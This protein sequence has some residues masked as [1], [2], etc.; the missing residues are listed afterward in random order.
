[1]REKAEFAAH[2]DYFHDFCQPDQLFSTLGSALLPSPTAYC[3]S[4]QSPHFA[5]IT[6]TDSTAADSIAICLLHTHTHVH[7]HLTKP[8]SLHHTLFLV[9]RSESGGFG[10]TWP[11][12]C[13]HCIFWLQGGRE[14]EGEYCRSLSLHVVGAA[15]RGRGMRARW[16]RGESNGSGSPSRHRHP[17][18]NKLAS[19][20]EIWHARNAATTAFAVAASADL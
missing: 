8:P 13:Y 20:N 10:S 12:V 14:R 3:N 18:S 5:T 1:M 6:T 19:R 16:G 11:R 7:A 9:P 15:A 2:V 17:P 4:H